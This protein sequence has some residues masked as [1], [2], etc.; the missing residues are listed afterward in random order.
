MGWVFSF[1]SGLP[2]HAPRTGNVSHSYFNK[3]VNAFQIGFD[4][5]HFW[6]A[7]LP[8]GDM[9]EL[10]LIEKTYGD[11]CKT[12]QRIVESIREHGTQLEQDS[13]DVAYWAAC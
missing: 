12:H 2:C 13:K 7:P 6:H 10:H 5:H 9:A 3:L 4:W 11:L 1:P 8:V